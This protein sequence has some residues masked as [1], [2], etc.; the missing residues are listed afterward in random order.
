MVR[1]QRPEITRGQSTQEMPEEK[2]IQQVLAEKAAERERE[3]QKQQAAAAAA[4][5]KKKMETTNRSQ[6]KFSVYLIDWL[7]A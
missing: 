3:K 1:M 6:S 7:I 2:Y 5:A 4:D